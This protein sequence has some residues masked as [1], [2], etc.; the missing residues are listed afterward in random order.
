VAVKRLILCLVPYLL[1]ATP[2]AAQDLRSTFL[3]LFRF[4][5]CG[6]QALLCL[7]NTSGQDAA[8]TF[9]DA[10]EGGN[11]LLIGFVADAIGLSV[12]SIPTPATSSASI[13]EFTPGGR[14]TTRQLSSGPIYGERAPSLGPGKLLVGILFARMKF[15]EL[16]GVPITDL[17]FNFRHVDIPGTPGLGNPVQE[18]N[19]LQV[20]MHLAVQTVAASFFAT[21]GITNW[22]D[23]GLAIPL[24]RTSL[25][26][27]SEAQ[28]I[29]FG[30]ASVY[31]FG[32][33]GDDPKLRETSFQEGSATGIGDMGLRVKLN[34]RQS[35]RLG[36]A[37]LGDL[38]LPTGSEANLLGLG[39]VAA[40]G[41]GVAS[42]E[43][44][45]FTP[46][47]NLGY[48]YR[49][50]ADSLQNH[51]V[52]ATIGFDHLL[53]TGVTLA[54]D[55]LSEFELDRS[56]L[57]VPPDIVYTEPY[58]R[59]VPATSIPGM[60]DSRI[61]AT[62]GFKWAVPCA[63]SWPTF[64][65]TNAER[66]RGLTIVTSAVVPLNSGGLR[67]GIVWSAGAQFKF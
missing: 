9:S 47:V 32:G 27:W 22:M 25:S 54:V 48:L 31:S 42:M 60:R 8:L 16:R 23:V 12:S 43:F 33:P 10:L 49:G 45:G 5:D 53:T 3:N 14:I 6:E 67:P 44:G 35:G 11:S 37:F 50:R 51:A 41:M 30:S 19:L 58:T 29:P 4:G 39:A 36:V 46:H 57:S 24:V 62:F 55:V 59:T 13:V 34:L 1:A 17:S 52:L 66:G 21:Y 15:N 38:R 28:I 18:N 40:R 63:P 20:N 64:C 26:G 65:A 2:L 7:T 56:S 61:D